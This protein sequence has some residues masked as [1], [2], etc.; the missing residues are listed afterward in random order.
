MAASKILQ[1]TRRGSRLSFPASHKTFFCRSYLAF[2]GCSLQHQALALALAVIVHLAV[3]PEEQLRHLCLSDHGIQTETRRLETVSSCSLV[4]SAGA[5]RPGRVPRRSTSCWLPFRTLARLRLA[6]VP[7]LY[8][9]DGAMKS[10][11][12]LVYILHP[13]RDQGQL[14]CVRSLAMSEGIWA[15]FAASFRALL[16]TRRSS[17]RWIQGTKRKQRRS[18]S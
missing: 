10:E 9:C 11:S 6:D 8:E 5:S 12:N 1:V 18:V 7:W 4:L 13:V 15:C 17:R 16:R 3:E 14:P 2:R